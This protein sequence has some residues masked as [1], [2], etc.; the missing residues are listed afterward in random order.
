MLIELDI[1]GDVYGPGTGDN[2]PVLI[3]KGIIYK[4]LFDTNSIKA[5][6]YI[7]DKGIILKSY[8]NIIEGEN[9]YKAKH[10]YSDIINRLQP[11]VI[12]GFRGHGKRYIKN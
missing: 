11:I 6:Q 7:S 4:K 3:K 2:P 8:V 10:K 12:K 9:T 5:E 1:I